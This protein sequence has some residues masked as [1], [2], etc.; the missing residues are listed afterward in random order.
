MQRVRL[1]PPD[2]HDTN[3]WRFAIWLQAN[4]P[5]L[6][7][8]VVAFFM[9]LVRAYF[10]RAKLTKRD[11]AEAVICAAIVTGLRPVMLTMGIGDDFATIVGVITGILGFRFFRPAVESVARRY[12]GHRGDK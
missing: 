9:V 4:A 2:P 8:G 1:M 10:D 7:A 6:I 3:T 11:V 5:W 12:L